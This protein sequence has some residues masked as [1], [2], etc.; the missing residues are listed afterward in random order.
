M[1]NPFKTQKFKE[2]FQKWN[3]I[4]EASG[5]EEIEDFSLP[6]PPLKRWHALD[7][8]KVNLETYTANLEYYARARDLVHTYPFK[9]PLQKKVWRLH[10]EGMPM[11][12]IAESLKH[13]KL[14]KSTVFNIIDKISKQIKQ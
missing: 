8:K 12:M 14:R 10:A 5:H 9:N 11:R 3:E 1:S 7:F 4:L 6:D 13:S 2:D